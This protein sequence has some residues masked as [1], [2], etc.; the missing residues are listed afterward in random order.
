MKRDKL[1]SLPLVNLVRDQ[2]RCGS[3]QSPYIDITC[4]GLFSGFCDSLHI[5][6][7]G[8]FGL[9]LCQKGQNMTTETVSTSNTD[10]KNIELPYEHH[11]NGGHPSTDNYKVRIDDREFLIH[12]RHPT[13]EELLD[14]VGRKLCAYELIELLQG[15]NRE[16]EPGDSIDLHAHGKLG[17]ITAHREIVTIFIKGKPHPIK[18]GE[19]TVDQILG[20]VGETSAGYNL[21]EEKPGQP[22]MPVPENEKL[23]IVG[24]EVFTYQVKSGTSS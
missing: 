4:Q 14:L 3:R 5:H 19:H 7:Q 6:V 18:R 13:I 2:T 8:N 10:G 15:E 21:Y 24:C 23:H 1:E 9:L 22:P 16:V 11:Q 20:L 12:S 17:F